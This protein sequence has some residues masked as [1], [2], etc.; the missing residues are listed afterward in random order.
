MLPSLLEDYSIFFLCDIIVLPD[1][2]THV[3]GNTYWQLSS[4]L[5]FYHH[6]RHHQYIKSICC[7]IVLSLYIRHIVLNLWPWSWTFTV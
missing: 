3:T 5:L 4:S 7:R 1:V 6:C 2:S